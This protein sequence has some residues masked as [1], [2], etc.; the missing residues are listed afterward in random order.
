MA[1]FSCQVEMETA[2]QVEM[3]TEIETDLIWMAKILFLFEILVMAEQVE[4]TGKEN[5]VLFQSN[6]WSP[7]YN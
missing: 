1:L 3:E 4:C 2:E 7:P 6:K 5:F